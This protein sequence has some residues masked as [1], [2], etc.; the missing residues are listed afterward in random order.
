MANWFWQECQD[1]STG[2]GG[3]ESYFQQMVLDIPM[4][5]TKVWLLSHTYTKTNLEWIIKL[6]MRAKSTKILE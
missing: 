2:G 1:N 4:Q 5:K 3:E 6:K